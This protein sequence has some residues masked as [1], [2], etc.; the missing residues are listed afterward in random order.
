MS[1]GRDVWESSGCMAEDVLEDNKDTNGFSEH[2]LLDIMYDTCKTNNSEVLASAIIQHLQSLIAE[3]A[4]QEKLSALR[5]LLDPDH[6]DPKVSRETFHSTM[7]EWIAQ[8]SHN[9]FDIGA[10]SR[11]WPDSS[12]MPVIRL[13]SS[14]TKS[15]A[16]SVECFRDEQDLC[17]AVAELKQ[18]H[19][20][21]NKQKSSL[22]MMVTQCEDENLQLSEEVTELQAQL[23]R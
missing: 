8:C 6:Q 13:D 21:M 7:T 5:V 15:K 10:S 2:E 14:L 20:Q 22:L 18:A 16:H 9:S 17:S 4:E 3:S 19:Q 1:G 12:K 23:D 11:S